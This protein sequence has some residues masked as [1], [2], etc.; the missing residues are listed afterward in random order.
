MTIIK[1]TTKPRSIADEADKKITEISEDMLDTA[2]T[3]MTM[4][5]DGSITID[6]LE[7]VE[8]EVVVD[9]NID[10]H[11]ENLVTKVSSDFLETL[12]LTVISNF[13]QDERSRHDWL[14]T[15]ELGFDLLGVKVEEKNEPFEGA[16]SAQHPL[17]MES[18]VKFQSKA[19]SELL[20]AD[21]P[22]RTKLVGEVTP[23][24]ELKAARV[25]AHMNHQITEEMTEFI[26]DTERLL[27]YMSLFGSGYK[28]TYYDPHL[29]RPCSDFVPADQFVVP[30]SAPDLYRAPHYTHILYKYPHQLEADCA[31]GM[32]VKPESGLGTPTQPK[33]TVV[34]EK[35]ARIMGIQEAYNENAQVYTLY[36]QHMMLHIPGVDVYEDSEG[37]ELA[38]PYIVTVDS[39]SMAVL[40]IRRNWDRRDSKRRKKVCFTP[41]NFVPSFGFYAYGFLHLLGN[42]QLTLTAALRS[43]VDAGQFA[44]LQG[45]FKLKGVRISDD[46]SPIRPGQFKDIEAATM[47]I[48]KAIMP[49]PFKEPSQTLYAM[50]EFLDRKGQ[51]FADSTEQV[52][53][54]SSNYGPVG[55]TMALLEASTKFFSAIHKRLHASLK[56]ELR[57]IAAINRETLDENGDYNANIG[58]MRIT[59]GDYDRG[60][61]VI[62]VSDPNISSAAHRMAKAQA[63]HSIAMQSP[64][65]HDMREVLRHVYTNMDYAN[66]EKIL[67]PPEEAQANDPM[68]DIMLASQG[69]PIKAF[70][71]QEHQAHIAIKQAFLQDPN[72]GANP[73]MQKAAM[74][75][76]AN[77]QEHML[78][79]FMEQVKAQSEIT[80]SP[81]EMA[82][83]EVAKMNQQ[84]AMKK[85]EASQQSP[86]D[87]AALLL[88]QAELMDSKT[89]ER[90]QS[91]NELLGAA[92]LELD[93]EELDL[94]KLKERNRMLEIDKKAAKDVD[95][96]VTTKAL[97]AM[98]QGMTQSTAGKAKSEN[99]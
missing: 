22:V 76:M 9:M 53:A 84:E 7:P 1:N 73:V 33:L 29:E 38:S 60:V 98:I 28:K 47:D 27:L 8:D 89:Q 34:Q 91:F 36:E 70:E 94:A 39:D 14:K 97:D 62:P 10:D 78:M 49:L 63:L 96:I 12:A 67:P 79:Q 90:K 3:Q 48:S 55:T 77:I 46:G 44:T 35:A 19:S 65:F 81:M 93:K 25:K 15:I 54:D 40:G 13:E 87:Q 74:A 56:H 5:E 11:D 80:Q 31:A 21:G 72:S 30:N 26:P 86:R 2:D 50:L 18:G 37:Y 71:G 45:G 82:A 88:A 59:R 43:L 85:A 92:K 52:I 23:E 41:Y 17:L 95:K 51:K 64:Q 75:I 83:Q 66:V 32:Y 24:K 20:P 61:D 69:K 42:L 58:S 68:T 16:C 99:T 6:F 57:L 4:N